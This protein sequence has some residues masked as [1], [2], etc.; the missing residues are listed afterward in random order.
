MGRQL[1]GGRGDLAGSWGR[2][3]GVNSLLMSPAPQ[4]TNEPRPAALIDVKKLETPRSSSRLPAA[5]SEPPPPPHTPSCSVHFL[6][7][8]FPSPPT[9][10]RIGLGPSRPTPLWCPSGSFKS[11][12]GR[13]LLCRA[14]RF[15][16]GNSPEVEYCSLGIEKLVL[17][18]IHGIFEPKEFLP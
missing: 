17:D 2:E 8:S 18:Y 12:G 10:I 7:S 1:A 14:G 9:Q 4:A 3:C 16:R 11:Q 6:P 13:H 15:G 5:S